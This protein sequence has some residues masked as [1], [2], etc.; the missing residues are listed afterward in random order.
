MRARMLHR[1]SGKSELLCG[2]FI[3]KRSCLRQRSSILFMDS[4]LGNHEVMVRSKHQ[5]AT[6]KFD[7]NMDGLL[8]CGGPVSQTLPSIVTPR[9]AGCKP[10][11]R[12][13]PR[14][15]G[16]CPRTSALQSSTGTRATCHWPRTPQGTGDRA[17]RFTDIKI[18]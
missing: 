11:R 2:K 8:K 15:T 5:S 4:D 9:T 3:C 1:G 12:G 16:S 13:G 7:H 10:C 14:S 6:H 17:T 18:G